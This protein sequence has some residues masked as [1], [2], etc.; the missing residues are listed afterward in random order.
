MKRTLLEDST[1]GYLVND[2]IIIKYTIELVVSSGVCSAVRGVRREGMVGLGGGLGELGRKV[3]HF[4]VRP[5]VVGQAQE[6]KGTLFV[7]GSPSPRT[8]S[9]TRWPPPP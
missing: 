2:T 1:K 6:Q 8:L 3:C 5:P 4:T 7:T 9:H